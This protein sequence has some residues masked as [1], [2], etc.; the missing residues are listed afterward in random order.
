M[1]R[2]TRRSL[3]AMSGL[4]L[5]GAVL[6]AGALGSRAAEEGTAPRTTVPQPFDAGDRGGKCL[7][8]TF[9]SCPD[10]CVRYCV[11]SLCVPLAGGGSACTLDCEGPESCQSPLV[12]DLVH[13]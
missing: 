3:A 12:G 13:P 10:S 11:P 6:C 9:S 4:A 1:R 8:H 5:F 7:A 2:P